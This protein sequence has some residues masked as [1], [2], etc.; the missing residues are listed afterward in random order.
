MWETKAQK[1]YTHT[2]SHA[3]SQCSLELA[4]LSGSEHR[5]LGSYRLHLSGM[6]QEVTRQPWICLAA[7]LVTFHLYTQMKLPPTEAGRVGYQPLTDW[8][9]W[10]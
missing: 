4:W 10:I 5:K 7:K 3:A 2:Q 8:S 1:G 6:I 9:N